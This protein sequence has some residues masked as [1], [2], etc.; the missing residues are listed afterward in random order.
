MNPECQHVR[1]LM[2]SYLSGEL[3]IETNHLVLRH[4]AACQA[5]ET[6][7][8]RRRR[9][10]TLLRQSLD[11][12]VDVARVRQRVTQ[13]I[14]REQRSWMHGTRWWAAAAALIAGVA[15]VQW[16]SRPVDAAAYDDSAGNHIACA[17][18][19]P[20]AVTYD[21][22]RA[23]HNLVPPF[24]GLAEGIGLTHGA[25]H[26][27]DAHMCP[28]QGRDYAHVVLRGRA[29]TLSIFIE[30]AVRGRLPITPLK[31]MLPGAPGDVYSAN[32]LGYHVSA[33]ATPAHRL[34]LVSEPPTGAPDDVMNEILLSAVRFVRTLER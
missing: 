29:D 22:A 2:D 34:F 1:E 25:Y 6:E 18:A 28:Y 15:L 4:F 16:L 9:L 32:R 7:M 21:A 10:R 3:S 12:P 23:A 17:L 5:C 19:M 33:T 30:P 13:A 8:T 24:T 31:T 11:V 20:A 26:V 27:I 14:D